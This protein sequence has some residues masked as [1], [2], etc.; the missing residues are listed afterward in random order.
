MGA[1]LYFAIGIIGALGV[2][3]LPTS[4]KI[5]WAMG[6]ILSSTVW[7]LVYSYRVYQKEKNE[8]A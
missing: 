8:K 4:W 2:V 6:L 5:V 1:K 7:I 3:W